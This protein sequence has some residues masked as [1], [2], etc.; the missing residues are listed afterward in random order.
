MKQAFIL[1]GY[2]VWHK[3]DPHPNPTSL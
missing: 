2:A 3:T 1:N